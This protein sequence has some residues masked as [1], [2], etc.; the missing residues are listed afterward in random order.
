MPEVN[1][2]IGSVHIQML[3]KLAQKGCWE[4]KGVVPPYKRLVFVKYGDDC[5]YCHMRSHCRYWQRA[6]INALADLEA[7]MRVTIANYK[8]AKRE[9]KH[10]NKM[11]VKE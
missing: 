7:S 6:V 5:N 3:E 8:R 2:E 11:R 10:I 1:T 4:W 9:A